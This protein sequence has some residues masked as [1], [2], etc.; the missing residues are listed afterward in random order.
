MTF[1]IREVQLYMAI[2]MFGLGLLTFGTGV[3]VLV[4][5]T[6]NKDLQL[7]E[8]QTT[9]LAAKGFTEQIAGLVGNASA[10]LNALNDMV[11][12]ARGI[13]IFLTLSGI[14]LMTGSIVFVLQI[15]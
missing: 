13:G 1:N 11:H 6:L 5:R 14:L 12:T 2:I 10:L 15:H 7:I 4:S 9:K 3:I 8:E